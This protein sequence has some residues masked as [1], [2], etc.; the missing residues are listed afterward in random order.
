MTIMH[1]Q[2]LNHRGVYATTETAEQHTKGFEAWKNKRI[3]IAREFKFKWRLITAERLEKIGNDPLKM[4]ISNA[5]SERGL[6]G[7]G[8]RD[9][10]DRQGAPRAASSL[11][12]CLPAPEPAFS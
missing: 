7:W 9:E 12:T 11:L 2:I 5:R 6:A 10:D 3:E 1:F 4:R 8:V